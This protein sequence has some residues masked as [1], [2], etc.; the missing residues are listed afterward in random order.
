MPKK[1]RKI[2]DNIAADIE[3]IKKSSK[4]A[5][6]D[7]FVFIAQDINNPWPLGGGKHFPSK[8]DADKFIKQKENMCCN[9]VVKVQIV[10]VFL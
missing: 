3:K 1:F 2:P 7:K 5:A 6:D 8:V 4:K 9:S 10:E